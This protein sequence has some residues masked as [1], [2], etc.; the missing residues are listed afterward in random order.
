MTI[1]IVLAAS[2]SYNNIWIQRVFFYIPLL[3]FWPLFFAGI[4]FHNITTNADNK[5]LISNYWMVILCLISQILLFQY[6]GRSKDYI[7]FEEYSLMIILYFIIFTLFA[8]GKLKFMINKPLLFLGKISFA[9]YLIH[10]K[11]SI[12]FIIP[13]LCNRF[14]LNFWIASTIALICSIGLATCITYLIEVPYSRKMKNK[15]YTSLYN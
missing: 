6:S 10:Q 13:V 2:F 8:N 14:H 7:Y 11:I 3:Q 9:L 1:F 5:N 4:L 12:E 15:L